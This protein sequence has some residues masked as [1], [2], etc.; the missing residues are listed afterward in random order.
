MGMPWWL[1][2]LLATVALG[3]T[4]RFLGRHSEAA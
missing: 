3:L 2:L 4:L 1:G